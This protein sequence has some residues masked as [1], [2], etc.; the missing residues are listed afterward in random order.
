MEN[1]VVK[2]A[3]KL[4]SC[5]DDR[6]QTRASGQHRLVVICPPPNLGLNF[7]V[8]PCWATSNVLQTPPPVLSCAKAEW[9]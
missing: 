7:G 4:P 1:R 2:L 6:N 5:L 9:R 3:L 8:P